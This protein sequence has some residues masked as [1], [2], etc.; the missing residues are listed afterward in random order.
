MWFA[1]G[2]ESETEQRGECEAICVFGTCVCWDT[3]NVRSVTAEKESR[4]YL[5]NS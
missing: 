5:Q 4:S 3:D 1:C 2:G